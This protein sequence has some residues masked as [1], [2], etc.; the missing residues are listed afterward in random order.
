M[1]LV[2]EVQVQQPFRSE[3]PSNI[4]KG[5]GTWAVFGVS[6]CPGE[7]VHYEF[8]KCFKLPYWAR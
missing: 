7:P 8:V 6:M 5:N 2:Q 4:L 1:E 3:A